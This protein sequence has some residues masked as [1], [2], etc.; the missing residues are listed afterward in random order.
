MMRV[1]LASGKGGTGK[2]TISLALWEA[3]RE[4]AR[5]LDCDVEEP[6]CHLFIGDGILVESPVQL[7][8]PV[9]DAQRCGQCGKCVEACQFNAL[10]LAGEAG[11]L[12]FEELCH[13]CGACVRACPSRAISEVPAEVGAVVQYEVSG[14]GDFAQGLL[15]VGRASAPAVIRAVKKYPWPSKN[16]DSMAWEILDAPPGT[17]CSLVA[18]LKGCDVVLLVAEPTPFG[19]HDLK[20]AIEYVGKLHKPWAVVVNRDRPGSLLENY[21]A[22][23][24]IPIWLRIPQDEKIARGYA[25]G[26]TL[27]H[28]RPDLKEA[29]RQLLDRC[30]LAAQ[31]GD[32]YSE[33]L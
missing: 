19:L 18:T 16:S 14:G 28:S 31:T 1:A 33:V 21:C 3:N 11:I 22:E 2:T 9:V 13:S 24:D 15:R 25:A 10:A 27:L 5:L 20:L 8:Y 7:P 6:N 17:S 12:V 4:R 30:T 23:E 32:R 29:F 26:N